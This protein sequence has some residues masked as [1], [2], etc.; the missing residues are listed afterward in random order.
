MPQGHALLGIG[1]HK[2]ACS[3]LGAAFDMLS[4]LVVDEAHPGF[5]EMS[6]AASLLNHRASS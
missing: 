6:R 5:G 2:A 4:G 1:D 3:L